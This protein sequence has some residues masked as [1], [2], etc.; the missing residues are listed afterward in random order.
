ML[1]EGL[2]LL[3]KALKKKTEKSVH[4]DPA[5]H[6]EHDDGETSHYSGHVHVDGRKV[7][8]G[9]SD[10][11]NET[12]H[13]EHIINHVATKLGVHPDKVRDHYHSIHYAM[14]DPAKK[15]FKVTTGAGPHE[16]IKV[17]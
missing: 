9:G 3:E 14:T 1:I 17:K 16:P 12:P 6:E 2:D 4:I 10:R 15:P 8:V 13:G 7:H 11:D 5:G